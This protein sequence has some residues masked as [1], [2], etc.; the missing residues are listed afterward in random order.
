LD[1]NA[2]KSG[3]ISGCIMDEKG[4][5]RVIDRIAAGDDAT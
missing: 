3:H 5:L 2:V 1:G 4:Y